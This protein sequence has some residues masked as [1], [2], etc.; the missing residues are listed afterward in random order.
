MRIAV[1]GS[2]KIGGT[3]GLKWAGAGHQVVFGT[4]APEGPQAQGLVEAAFKE[5][6]A[7]RARVDT[8]PNAIQAGEAV[9][10]AIPGA[11]VEALLAVHGPALDGKIVI[12]ATNRLASAEASALAAIAA[13][14]P[15]ARAF[16]AFN[17][18][19]WENFAEPRFG[20]LQADHFYCGPEGEAQRQ[21]EGLIADIGL[22]PVRVGDLD[23]AHLLDALTRLWFALAVG[24]GLGRHLAFKLLR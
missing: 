4:R 17:S 2:G 14:A 23:Q 12:D 7:G 21:V 20:E 1:L 3:L 16:R 6:G 13:R 10:L 18:L 15:A 24:Q 5:K 19:G 11:A 22:R 8:I 9:L